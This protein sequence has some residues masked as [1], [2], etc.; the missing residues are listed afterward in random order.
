MYKIGI[1]TDVHGNDVALKVVLNKLQE[2]QVDEIISL[3]D[4]I[5]IGPNSNEVLKIV[6]K[7]T[8]FTTIRGNHERY[9][10]Q[11]FFN[12]LSCTE[13]SH[14]CWVKDNIDL[15]FAEFLENTKYFMTKEI[16]GVKIGFIHYPLRSLNPDRFEYIVH[17]P[18]V[19]NLDILFQNVEGD[20]VCYGHEHIASFVEGKKLYL[21]PGSCGCPFPEK[22]ITRC[23]VLTI[24]KGH[25]TYEHFKIPYDSS[26][27]VKD[28]FEKDMPDK[29][30]I[31]HDFYLYRQEDK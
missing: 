16:E 31:A 5:A 11:G 9:Y 19:E 22:D 25:L 18:T 24:D 12:P 3:G 14:Q 26:R 7:L 6:T 30:F 10:L 28:M 29:D 23:M 4:L 17:N 13:E 2:E 15:E 20:V 21:D 8:N 27:V 1:F